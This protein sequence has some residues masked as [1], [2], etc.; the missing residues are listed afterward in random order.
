MFYFPDQL[1]EMWKSPATARPNQINSHE[2]GLSN[3]KYYCSLLLIILYWVTPAVLFY[4]TVC[5]RTK[6]INR[7][8][9]LEAFLEAA[10]V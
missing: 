3:I 6:V 4:E 5:S 8:V 1:A 2:R 9:T 10:E 7:G